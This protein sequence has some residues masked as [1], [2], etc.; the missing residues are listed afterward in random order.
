[1]PVCPECGTYCDDTYNFCTECGKRLIKPEAR[2]ADDQPDWQTKYSQYSKAN[3]QYSYGFES[4][5]DPVYEPAQDNDGK[6]VSI[7]SLVFGI[8]SV[9]CLL[10]PLFSLTGLVTGIIGMVK[11]KRIPARI[12]LILSVM[13]LIL[14]TIAFIITAINGFDFSAISIKNITNLF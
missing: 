9:V 10:F 11:G 8:L 14:F 13:S 7:V 4:H 12:G 5:T 3:S 1:M 2:S 6:V